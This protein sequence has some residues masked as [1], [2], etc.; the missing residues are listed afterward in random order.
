M[1]TSN[2]QVEPAY[3]TRAHTI[4]CDTSGETLDMAELW[5]FSYLTRSLGAE[6]W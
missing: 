2:D 3:Y 4:L 6:S 1:D 5:R